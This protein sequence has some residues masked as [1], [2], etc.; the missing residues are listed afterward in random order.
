MD[1]VSGGLQTVQERADAEYQARLEAINNG[2][3]LGLET[4]ISYDEL[5]IRAAMD[6]EAQLT[7]I[8]QNATQARMA[9]AEQER[10]AKIGAMQTLFGGLSTLMNTGSK[11]LFEVGKRRQLRRR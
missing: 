11:K 6:R 3:A 1:S 2:R 7:A 4:T 8:E 9:L 10:Q 5:E